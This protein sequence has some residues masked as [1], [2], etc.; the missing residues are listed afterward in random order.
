MKYS[1]MTF[2]DVMSGHILP[3]N[4][5]FSTNSVVLCC[6][7]KIGIGQGGHPPTNLLIINFVIFVF[8]MNISWKPLSWLNHLLTTLTWKIYML[9]FVQNSMRWHLNNTQI[10]PP[11]SYNRII[12]YVIS[13]YNR[14][15][16]TSQQICEKLRFTMMETGTY[17]IWIYEWY[18]YLHWSE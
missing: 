16:I 15:N 4:D 3:V 11:K 5:S 17:S 13:T 18:N 8:I 12:G 2:W 14:N 1:V 6:L 7:G 9:F 10:K